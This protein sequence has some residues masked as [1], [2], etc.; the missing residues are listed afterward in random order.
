MCL[1]SSDASACT[2][3]IVLRL[4]LDAPKVLILELAE[5]AAA[6]TLVRTT[7]GIDKTFALDGEKGGRPSVQIDGINF[8]AAVMHDDVVD[9]NAITCNDVTAMLR[10]YGVEAARSTLV[11]EVR[12][13]F[14]AYGIAVD[15]RH[16]SLIADFMTHGGEYR[17]CNR[18]G[19]ESC[20][21]PLLK[22]SFETSAHFLKDAAMRGASDA[23]TSAAARIVLGQPVGLGT[24]HVSVHVDLT[25][26]STT[27]ALVY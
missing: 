20:P 9:A 13:V 5:A 21:S 24:G 2:C 6:A 8:T 18:L 10:T 16:L 4:A 1:C 11:A 26:R 3:T 17:A 7:E 14:G 23:M 12:G 22:M 27:Q 19:I 15:F 25:A